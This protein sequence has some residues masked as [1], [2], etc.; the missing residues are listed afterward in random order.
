M[1]QI[2]LEMFNVPA[3]YEAIRAV[4]S[5]RL[6]T[7]FVMDYGDGVP[8]IVPIIEASRSRC[9]SSWKHTEPRW[10]AR[11]PT[12]SRTFSRSSSTANSV[13]QYPET[14]AYCCIGREPFTK[15]GSQ[16]FQVGKL[17]AP[18]MRRYS[19]RI[20]R[21]V[22]LL[23]H[24]GTLS[25]MN[26]KTQAVL[27]LCASRRTP[28]IVLHCGDGVSHTNCFVPSFVSFFGHRDLTAFLIKILPSFARASSAFFRC[29][30]RRLRTAREDGK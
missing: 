6:V 24:P 9:L 3:V 7:G 28:S 5:L 27:P 21:S 1:T 26:V 12:T 29:V 14:A 25:V 13:P 18:P 22:C 2:V 11:W 16:V 4:L 23:F 19:V 17:L 30:E 8:H 15:G 20:G 10:E